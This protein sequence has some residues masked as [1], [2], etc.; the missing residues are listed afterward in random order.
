LSLAAPFLPGRA[1]AASTDR[2][3][4][5]QLLTDR[6]QQSDTRTV[7]QECATLATDNS[8]SSNVSGA[9][10]PTNFVVV[11]GNKFALYRRSS[12]ALLGQM[13]QLL[14]LNFFLFTQRKQKESILLIDELVDQA[15]SQ[16]YSEIFDRLALFALHLA[17]SGEWEGSQWPD[18]RV[19]GWCNEFIRSVAWKHGA[20]QRSAFIESNLDAFISN[21]LDAY[22]GTK[23]KVRNNYLYYLNLAGVEPGSG[24][25]DLKPELWGQNACWL[26]WD[27]LSYQTGS[28][29]NSLTE[30]IASFFEHEIFKLLG[31]SKEKGEYI[32]KK[33]ANS[34]LNAGATNRF[35]A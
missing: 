13:T 19:A 28:D 33:A 34:Y 30:L 5:V 1:E 14:P 2:A 27:R 11:A 26:F 9:V 20:W 31:C 35:A 3:P 7:L 17:I 22:P 12:C 4:I 24:S 15:V 23:V 29:P 32:A 18:G 8:A 25:V 21:R 10:G 6:A 16:P